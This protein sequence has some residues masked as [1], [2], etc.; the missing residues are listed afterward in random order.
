[1]KLV[2]RNDEEYVL[3]VNPLSIEPLNMDFDGDMSSSYVNHDM[4]AL[5]EMYTNAFLQN[6]V[7]Y[8]SNDSLLSTIRHDALY[9]AYILSQNFNKLDSQNIKY[10]IDKLSELPIT[11]EDLNNP[12]Q[13][14]LISNK[15]F[16]Y[17]ICLINKWLNFDEVVINFEITKKQ[18]QDISKITYI[19]YNKNSKKYY[20]SLGNFEKHLMSFISMTNFVPTINV[21]QMS[22]MVNDNLHLLINKI[23]SDNQYLSYYI[24]DALID[25]AIDNFDHECNLYK[26]YKSGSR[27]NKSQLAR[28]CINIGPFADENNIIN[29]EPINSS[30]IEGLTEKQFFMSSYGTRK[31]LVDKSRATPRSGYLARTLVMAMSCME[32]AEDDCGT[33][34]GIKIKVH[35]K[36]HIKSLIGKYYK[37]HQEDNWSLIRNLDDI[38]I[39][40]EIILRTPMKCHTKDFKICKKCFGEKNNRTKY[41]GVVAAQ[42]LTERLTQLSMRSFHT[43]GSST[44][45]PIPDVTKTIKNHLIDI[46]NTPDDSIQ[47]IFDTEDLPISEFEKIEG[48]KFINKNIIEYSKINHEVKNLDAVQVINTVNDILKK[49]NVVT[50]TPDQYYNKLIDAILTVGITYSS[51]VEMVLA[52]LFIVEDDKFWRYN[53]D[54]KILYKLSD[55]AVAAKISPLLGFLYQPNKITINGFDNDFIDV[56]SSNKPLTFHERIFLQKYNQNRGINLDQARS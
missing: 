35:S 5:K 31:G 11:I 36:D 17:G 19:Y 8:D 47:L 14:V 7:E 4:T 2:P 15:L 27:F 10:S 18:I 16:T 34:D 24:N 45:E 39:G 46:Q 41:I 32:L 20:D 49:Q 54:K 25:K 56:I 1:M 55:K 21:D 23:P 42:C 44:L 50:E 3:G 43:S 53:Y 29:P 13:T 52:H 28:S 9:A 6:V 33:E 22:S 40:S 51:Y 12:Y 30:L 38:N 26:L 37:E 48:Y